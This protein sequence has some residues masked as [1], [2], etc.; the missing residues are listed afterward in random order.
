MPSFSFFSL[1]SVLLVSLDEDIQDHEIQLLQEQVS[2][3]V[4]PGK[5]YGVILDLQ[6]LEVMDSYLAGEL[7]KLA[8]MLKLMKAEMV[9]AGLSVP[10][11]LALLDFAIELPD[12]NFALDVEQA[13]V[14]LQ[15]W[16]QKV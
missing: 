6:H 11:V 15:G 14:R 7:Q 2:A 5:V 10:V 13:M 12:V 4:S 1:G 8:N 9:V 16:H 3:R